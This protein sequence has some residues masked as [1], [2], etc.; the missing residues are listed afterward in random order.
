MNFRVSGHPGLAFG[1]LELRISYSGGP[2]CFSDV[3]SSCAVQVTART[4]YEQDDTIA[5][6][7]QLARGALG[8]FANSEK[9]AEADAAIRSECC[10]DSR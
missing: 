5:S 10:A 4:V 8:A 3:P 9:A 7:P 6:L 2:K 1:R